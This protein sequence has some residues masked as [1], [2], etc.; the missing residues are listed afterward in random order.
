MKFIDEVRI[1]VISGKGGAGSV[2]FR[3]EAMVPRGGPDGGD[4]GKGGNVVFRVDPRLHS[5]LDLRFQKT[6]KAEDGAPGEKQNKSGLDGKDLILTVP[7]GTMVKDDDGRVIYD[8]TEGQQV[9]LV[10]RE[11]AEGAMEHQARRVSS[12]CRRAEDISRDCV[13]VTVV[14][15]RR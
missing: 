4:G 5:L 8:L 3:R 6:Y 10:F 2:S 12:G 1:T 15:F 9:G 7:P 11:K 13:A 14:V